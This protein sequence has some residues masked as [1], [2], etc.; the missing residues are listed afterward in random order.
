M[1]ILG[2]VFLLYPRLYYT[3][4]EGPLATCSISSEFSSTFYTLSLYFVDTFPEKQGVCA[5]F[6]R[7]FSTCVAACWRGSFNWEGFNS[8]VQ[9]FLHS[10]QIPSRCTCETSSRS[11]DGSREISTESQVSF[12]LPF[13]TRPMKLLSSAAHP[14]LSC[15][16][17]FPGVRVSLRKSLL[18]EAMTSYFYPLHLVCGL[19]GL[20][21]YAGG[22]QW[23]S[24]DDDFWA[25]MRRQ[26]GGEQGEQRE[27]RSMDQKVRLALEKS[28]L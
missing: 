7:Y 2:M 16:A 24:S 28:C 26:G 12:F 11:G 6:G 9:H 13:Y 18:L 3:H 21:C 8:L 19:M 1:T 25:H 10:I 22:E 14:T 4:F 23:N 5:G 20:C 27:P 17:S 15:S